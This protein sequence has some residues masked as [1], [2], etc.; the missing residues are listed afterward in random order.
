MDRA[1]IK[2]SIRHYGADIQTVVAMEECAELIQAI[3][4]TIRDPGSRIVLANLTEE[5]ADVLISVAI[6]QEIYDVPDEM[7]NNWI[8]SKQQRI[9]E[10][11]R[12]EF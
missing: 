8:A 2:D 11:M 7:L 6:L 10:R 4:K 9:V 3:S 1:I 5:M 12:K